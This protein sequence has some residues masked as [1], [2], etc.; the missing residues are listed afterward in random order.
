MRSFA[1]S[2][3]N[4][5]ANEEVLQR[6]TDGLLDV[7]G[8]IINSERSEKGIDIAQKFNYVTFEIM[9]EM[10][11]GDP[12]DLRLEASPVSPFFIESITDIQANNV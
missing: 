2:M 3:S 5:M 4:I 9:G 6:R 12:W 11:F 7:I 1:F 8:G 10:S